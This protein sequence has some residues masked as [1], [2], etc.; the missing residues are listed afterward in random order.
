MNEIFDTVIIGSGP[1][2]LTAAIYNIRAAIKTVVIGGNQP[3]GQLTITTLVDNYPGFA[4][5]VGGVKLMMETIQQ[6]KNLGGEVRNGNVKK[7]EKVEGGFK[8]ELEDGK[9]LESKAVIVATGAQARWLNLG[10]EREM[11]GRGVSGCATCDGMFF[12]DKVVA[13]VGGGDVACQDAVFLAKFASKV[14]VLHRRD[15]L[16]AVATIQKQV[17]NNPKIELWWNWEVKEIKGGV[18]VEGLRVVNNK[19][20]EEKI[21]PVDGLFVAIGN[22]PATDF[23]KGVVELKENG[24]IVVGKNSEFLTMTSV[25]GIFAAGDCADEIYRQAIVAAGS[26]AK[27]GLDAERWLNRV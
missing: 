12:R 2:G 4:E 8:V 24:Y 17:L 5:G 26:G 16:R 6:V 13:V 7:V 22:K 11:V 1:A 18:R 3:G 14:Y 10:N 15:Q 21:L 25:E 20:N 19:T 27:A 23:L 9:V